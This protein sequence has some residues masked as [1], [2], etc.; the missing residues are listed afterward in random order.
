MV[1]RYVAMSR[2]KQQ[3]FSLR[4]GVLSQRS[5]AKYVQWLDSIQLYRVTATLFAP[6]MSCTQSV[7]VALLDTELNWMQSYVALYIP[8]RLGFK[9]K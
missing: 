9:N 5:V 6:P 7:A 1:K 8:L 4:T 3:L 2:A